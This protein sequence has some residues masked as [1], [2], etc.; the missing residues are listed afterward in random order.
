MCREA[1]G[2]ADC[3]VQGM[4]QL[5]T[6]TGIL[7]EEQRAFLSCRVL[8]SKRAT[9]RASSQ[10]HTTALRVLLEGLWEQ[11]LCVCQSKHGF[12]T[13]QAVR[14]WGLQKPEA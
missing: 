9:N 7:D 1:W 13:L 12:F 6:T 14:L 10:P 4:E 3:S 5:C 8:T 2:W 11:N